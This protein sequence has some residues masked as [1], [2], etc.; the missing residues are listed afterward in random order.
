MVSRLDGRDGVAYVLKPLLQTSA[1]DQ[2]ILNCILDAVHCLGEVWRTDG[3]PRFVADTS[4]RAGLP[5]EQDVRHLVEFDTAVVEAG[6]YRA[7]RERVDCVFL[8][9]Q[10]FLFDA[11]DHLAVFEYH[12]ARIVRTERETARVHT[13]NVPDH[14][15]CRQ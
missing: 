11:E 15:M 13:Q 8:S 4:G 6:A 7:R 9:G 10:S 1:T 14:M 3:R 2:I 12:R 5:R